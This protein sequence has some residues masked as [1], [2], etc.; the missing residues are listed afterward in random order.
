[1]KDFGFA[2]GEPETSVPAR[3]RISETLHRRELRLQTSRSVWTTGAC[4]R[5]QTR[6][7]HPDHPQLPVPFIHIKPWLF[8]RCAFI[9]VPVFLCVLRA[10]Q[11]IG[12]SFRIHL[13]PNDPA[14]TPLIGNSPPMVN[15]PPNLA[16]SWS[17]AVSAG[18]AA[19]TSDCRSPDLCCNPS[20]ITEPRILRRK[21]SGSERLL[22]PSH[23]VTLPRLGNVR[24]PI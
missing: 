19:A 1:P 23:V 18:P 16:K 4:S 10:K 11:N 20:F 9:F 22:H 21:L 6:P 17:A 15:A 8:L 5:F 3:R 7:P 2:P 14:S 13:I 24:S 12:K